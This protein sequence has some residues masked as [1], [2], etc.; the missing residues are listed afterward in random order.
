[1]EQIL[2]SLSYIIPFLVVLTIVVFIHELGHFAVARHN[3]VKVDVFSIGIGPELFGW[4][5]SKGTR[6]K[7]SLLPLGGYIKMLGDA[8]ASSRPDGEIIETLSEED[9]KRTLQSKTVG[10]RIAI[11]S[12][13]PIANYLLTIVLMTGL[14]MYSGEPIHTNTIGKVADNSV[15]SRAGLQAGDKITKINE[16]TINKFIDM[17]KAIKP[18]EGQEIHITVERNGT[19]LVLNG[20][21]MKIDEKTHEK[22]PVAQLGIAPDGFTYEKH[23]PVDAITTTLNVVWHRSVDTL[24]SLG[25]MIIGKRS[26][27]E[28]GGILSIGKM[29][30]DSVKSSYVDLIWFIAVLSLSLGLF[31]LLPIPVLDGGHILFYTIEGIRGKPVS[32]KVQ[33]YAFLAGLVVVLSLMLFSTW[34]DLSRLKFFSWLGF[35]K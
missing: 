21:M 18:L 6:W 13:G 5:D 10:Q 8:D 35:G 14:F 15:A 4:N 33:E 28:L 3:D 1:M 34:N 7:V 25:Q 9:K 29:A 26:A 20:E 17:V 2:H 24:S 22:K 12:A 31:N 19:S 32:E 27:D 30:G 16:T 11:V 23:G